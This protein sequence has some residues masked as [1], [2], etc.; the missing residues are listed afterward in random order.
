MYVSNPFI[1]KV[2]RLAVNDA[3]IGGL[4]YQQAALKYGVTKSAICKWVKKA[5]SLDPRS[6]IDTISSHPHHHPNELSKQVIE[7][8]ITLRKQLKRCAPIIH[9]HLKREGVPVSLSSVWRTLKRQNLVRRK[10]A[11]FITPPLSSVTAETPGSLIQADTIH[12]SRPD[13]SRFYVYSVLDTYTRLAYAEY[14]KHISVDNSLKVISNAIKQFGFPF[15]VIQ[16]DH[17]VEFSQ[18]FYF[19]LQRQSICLK[20]IRVR[21]PNDNAQVERFNRTLQEECFSSQIPSERTLSQK[22]EEYLVYYNEKR[23]HLSLNCLTPKEFVS[24]LLT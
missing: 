20:Y 7:K 1:P 12:F 5:Q 3:T 22:L 6:Y 2:R 4:T 19:A 15:K 17:G 8:I 13:S 24:K 11:H 14:H 23:L 21:R 16:T 18:S 10:R 9:A